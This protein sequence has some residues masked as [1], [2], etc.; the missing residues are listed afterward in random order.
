MNAMDAIKKRCTSLMQIII[1]ST[2][3]FFSGCLSE[4]QTTDPVVADFPVAYV[5]R[6]I[7]VNNQNQPLTID[8]R[9]LDD[10]H[11]GGDLY[12][13]D[14]SAAG[15][16]EHN[17]TDSFTHGMG[18]VK[19]VESSYDGTKL[20]FAMRAPEIE[21]ADDDE[22]P[23]WNIWEYNIAEKNLRRI[24]TSDITAEAGQDVAPH[25]L[26]DGRIIFSST[27]QRQSG[28]ILLDEGKPKFTAE[29]EDRNGPALV[30]HVMNSD[31]SDIHQV[32]FNQSND[33]DPTVI[34]SGEVVFSRWDNMGSS[35]AIN[36][37]K[38]RPDGTGLQ[39]LYGAHS[40]NSGT[41][42]AAIQFLAP[43]ELP[44]GRLVTTTLPFTG[45][46]G[47]G[48]LIAIDVNN[49]GDNQRAVNDI[50]TLSASSAQSPLIE[51]QIHTDNTISPDG[52]YRAAYPLHDGTGRLLVSWSPCRLLVD[53]EIVTCTDTL[54][55]QPDVVAAP[56]L[57]S[58]YIYDPIKKTHAPLVMPVEGT[59]VEEVVIAQKRTLPPILLDSQP[60]TNLAQT[61]TDDNSGVLHI[62]SVYDIDGNDSATPNIQTLADPAVTTA[63]NRP[64]RFLRIVKGVPLPNRNV[65]QIPNS[66]FG[67]SNQLMREIIGY[68]PIEPDGSVMVKVPANVPLTINVLDKNGRSISAR[69]QNWLQVRPGETKQ[70]NGCHTHS[71][72][73]PHG[74]DD[75]TVSV[76]SGATTS[77]LSFPNTEP[78]LI[79]QMGETMAQTRA[80]ISCET[81]CAAITPSVDVLFDDVWTDANVRAKDASFSYRYAD[82]TTAIPVSSSCITQWN[83]LC[84]TI[85]NYETHIHPLWS[86]D[87]AANTC[88]SC[89]I[90]VDSNSMPQLPAAQL[91]L[92][93]GPSND[94]ATQFN[95]YRELLV[96][97]N[98]V[99][100]DVVNNILQDRL[101]QATDVN[102]NPRFET[103]ANGDLILDINGDPIPVMVAV[104][105]NPSM[106]GNGAN[107]S[108]F[109]SKFD[110]G[111]SHAGWLTNAELRL[112]AE[113]LDIG[114][115]YYNNPFDVPE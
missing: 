89:H 68:A 108:S 72:G 10:F 92:S 30:L 14:R 98:E 63:D 6:P 31:G 54:L 101:V 62:R 45:S 5:K 91:D 100:L 80:R 36:L 66:A 77:G 99:E 4:T 103:D 83:S 25:Y 15:A 40:H 86:K 58:V 76:N 17:I 64:A 81:D 9:Q 95:A 106:S 47:G 110:A 34:S 22:Q 21:D 39:L 1:L 78:A 56:P 52:L 24:I 87:R 60:N 3:P 18:D 11:A 109:F 59:I 85:I 12:L 113:W 114:A 23:T 44:D 111:G 104:R 37:Y 20:L 61:L 53:D 74:R 88:T 51:A 26:P 71:S 93:D 46:N 38:M 43:R 96:A 35:N 27:R 67:P 70:C 19:D 50:Q 112:I 57:Y 49:Y 16:Q 29:N 75:A 33:F 94:V 73:I 115:Q 84:R 97:D 32:S 2:L 42:N 79:A 65:L 102:G 105:V 7:P 48:E 55:A 28:A 69:H 8:V 41:N 90:S 13:K 82:L 107:S